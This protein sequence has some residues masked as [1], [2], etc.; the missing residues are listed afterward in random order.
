MARAAIGVKIGLW[1]ALALMVVVAPFEGRAAA[2]A[3]RAVPVAWA[4]QITLPGTTLPRVTT[5]VGTT[6]TTPPTTAA[7]TTTTHPA[8]TAT[9]A[10]RST[11]APPP[12]PSVSST[13]AP[14]TTTPTSVPVS[15][16][17]APGPPPVTLPLATATQS[18]S[19]SPVFPILGGVGLVTFVGLLL[20]QWFL[21]RPGRRGPTL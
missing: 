14:T 5:T 8:T 18:G 3:S 17:P 10:P 4:T 21:T 1:S 6:S 9:T 15:T 12:P 19:I 20:A 7:A 13:E 2:D 11:T 16:I